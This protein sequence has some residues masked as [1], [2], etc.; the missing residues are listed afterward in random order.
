VTTFLVLCA[1]AGAT[2]SCAS[3]SQQSSQTVQ[4]ASPT[5]STILE[6]P[7]LGSSDSIFVNKYGKPTV[8]KTTSGGAAEETFAT[9]NSKIDT[10]SVA[11]E[12]GTNLVYGIEI[13]AP[14]DRPWDIAAGIALCNFY[15]PGDTVLGKPQIITTADGVQ[16]YYREGISAALAASVDPTYFFDGGSHQQVKPGTINA[17]Y[18]YADSQGFTISMCNLLFG[19]TADDH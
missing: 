11:L 9:G 12:P 7:V 16:M 1:L 6:R 13:S 19:T 10:F 8:H 4:T 5:T 2:E 15:L 17:S 14:V 3:T 18:Y